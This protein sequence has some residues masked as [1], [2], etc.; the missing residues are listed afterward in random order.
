MEKSFI[1]SGPGLARVN[2]R[3][4]GSYRNY[5][6]RILYMEVINAFDSCSSR[7]NKMF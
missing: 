4:D 3:E 7:V 2:P 6:K 5:A 1:T